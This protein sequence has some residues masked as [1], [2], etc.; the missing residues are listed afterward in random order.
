[1][2]VGWCE[3]SD[4]MRQQTEQMNHFAVA[5]AAAVEIEKMVVVDGDS[6]V[7][8]YSLASVA[9]GAG[10]PGPTNWANRPLHYCWWRQTVAEAVATGFLVWKQSLCRGCLCGPN[11]QEVASIS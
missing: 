1:G 8:R 7:V 10:V 6:I 11:V 2:V 9:V 4:V 5:Q 3:R